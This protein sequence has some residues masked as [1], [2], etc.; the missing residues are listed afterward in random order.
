LKYLGEFGRSFINLLKFLKIHC[1]FN[2]E[3]INT[4]IED[5]NK[6]LIM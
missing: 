1:R 6:V 2:A 5:I 3:E 4:G